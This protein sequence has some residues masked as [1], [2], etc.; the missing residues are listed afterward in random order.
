[1]DGLKIEWILFKK[2]FFYLDYVQVVMMAGRWRR[3]SRTAR[4]KRLSA[5][6]SSHLARP[7][8]LCQVPF[9]SE[10]TFR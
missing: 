5:A 6:A 7:S 10:F 4:N 9:V 2:D 8:L 3:T 1:M